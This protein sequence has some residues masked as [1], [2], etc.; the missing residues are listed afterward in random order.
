MFIVATDLDRYI[1]ENCHFK[2]E[3]RKK[4]S[5]NIKVNFTSVSL[6]LHPWWDS[7]INLV[8]K[9][10]PGHLSSLPHFATKA[11]PA[12]HGESWALFL[13]DFY[14]LWPIFKIPSSMYLTGNTSLAE[15]SVV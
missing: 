4:C 6:I 12:M 14:C 8:P 13:S 5:H 1:S 9:I 11:K 3:A 7:Q 10:R 15:P 2:G